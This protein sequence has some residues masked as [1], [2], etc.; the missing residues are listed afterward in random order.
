MLNNVLHMW[1]NVC[2][3]KDDIAVFAPLSSKTETILFFVQ[4]EKLWPLP[5]SD[6]VHR[7]RHIFIIL[8]IYASLRK[9][10]TLSKNKEVYNT[11]YTYL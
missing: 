6:L 3:H 5:L 9:G 1:C 4:S 8:I 10:L 11:I 2:F 7:N